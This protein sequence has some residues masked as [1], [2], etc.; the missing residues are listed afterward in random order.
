MR[1]VLAV[2]LFAVLAPAQSITGAITG[3]VTDPTDAVISGARV[4]LAS[5]ATGAE[6]TAPTNEAGRF[7]FGSLQPGAYTLSIEAEGFRRLVRTSQVS[8]A[9]TV[10]IT[11]LKL[12]VG[13]VTDSVQVTA[14]AVNVQ[15]ETA[16]RAGVL[17]TSQVQNLAIRGRNVTSLVS[18]L[19]GVVDLSDPENLAVN[20][21]FY[22]QGNRRNTNNVTIDGATVNAIGNNFNAVVAVSMDAVA[23]VKVLLSN[24]QAEYGRMSGANVSIVTKS[25]AREFHGLASYFKRNEALN[26]NDF[27]NNRLGRPR[28]RYRFDTWN[29]QLGGPAY[30]PG[31]FNRNRDKLFFFWSQEFWPL[32]IPTA[33]AQ[34][35]VPTDAERRGDFSQSLD[36]NNSLIVVRD[37]FNNRAPFPDNVIPANRAD[38]NGQALLKFLPLP[39]FT[40]RTVSRGAFNY[41]FQDLVEQPKRTDTLKL[42]Y[43]LNS[44]NLLTFSYSA[45]NDTNDGKVGIPA[46][47]G[48]FDIVRQRSENRG[49]LFLGRY[50]KIFSAA[51]INEFNAGYSTRPLN[52]SI[53]EADLKSI[54]RDTIGFRLGQLYPANNPLG[55]IPN[56]SFGGV[57][58]AA[59]VSFD[60][61]TPLT[62]THEIVSI[63]NTLT[64]TFRSHTLKLGFYFDRLWAENQ[65]TSGSFNGGFNFGRNVNNPLDTGY[66]Y[67]N[68]VLGVFNQYDEPTG[69]PFPVNYASNTEWFVQD[70][71]KLH[72]RLSLDLGVRFYWLPQSWIDGDRLAGFSADAWD[73]AQAVLLVEPARQGNT[74]V[75]RNPN[76]GEIVPATLIGA[77]ASGRGT[78][79]NG[80]VSPVQDPSVPR[81]LMDDPGVLL[82]PRL[83][84]AYDLQGDGKTAIRG[85]FGLFYNRM[86]HGIVLTDFSIQPPLVDRPSVF[87][88]RMN[89]LLSSA[90]VLFPANVLGLDR[91]PPIPRVMNFSLTVERDI[92]F[93]TVVDAGY[94]GSLGRHLLWQR[95][96]NAIPFGTNFM[97]SAI[98]P[99]T[100][101]P[102]PPNFLRPYPGYGNINIREPA[103]SSN[104]HS[105]QASANRRFSHRL[106][107][108]AS[109]TWSKSLD[110]VSGDNT[111]V[112]AL[113]PP[114]IWNYGLSS[115]DRTHV[116][117]ANWLYD[118][119][120][121][122]S[123]PAPVKAVANGWQISGIYTA[124]SG[125]PL[126]VGFS[127]VTAVDITG[128]PTDGPRI[129]VTG[130]PVLERGERSFDRFFDTSVF[131]LPPVGS[132][133][134]AARTVIRGPGINNWDITALKNFGWKERVR[135]QLR[136]E[137]YNVFN[138]A[139]YSALDTTARFDAQGRQVSTRFGQVT[140]TRPGRRIQLAL[141]IMF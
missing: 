130:N 140:A 26:A 104:Y 14:Q 117:K 93:Q 65:A 75:G 134:N 45:R 138:H 35:T 139:Q 128:S 34:R 109:Y 124:S 136:A 4:R 12:E 37:P 31:R 52:N 58:N 59:Q 46:G 101:R 21:D 103:G 57:P 11:D 73:A 76:T 2:V 106:Q 81:S 107:F 78:P 3:I 24:Y 105:L 95:N 51:L 80:M 86:S 137:F 25:G 119:P 15:T 56:T 94:V 113:V 96:L 63:S 70:T 122:K 110:Y 79:A 44:S 72:R 97:P 68:A 114:R 18:L 90:G 120:E 64:R 112:S 77:I 127:T 43:N 55:I 66:A 49:K 85:G 71:W 61:R 28:P 116:L 131:A 10:S 115:F 23:E 41:V 92:G 50:Q 82:A 47:A 141:R 125:A 7:F 102:L 126:P 129:D 123:G 1:L 36:V 39:N 27:F 29:Y 17:T 6:R 133:G 111:S 69:R 16:E 89:G 74:R 100:N 98:D 30:I 22:V 84:F 32:S 135:T 88:G 8:A 38:P 108:G 99:T 53:A 54:Q 9:E 20:W 62:T 48:N 118:L 60:N 5:S 87:F 67:A 42:D 19:P 40:D 13:Q 91:H 33:L 83:G 121:W 132:F